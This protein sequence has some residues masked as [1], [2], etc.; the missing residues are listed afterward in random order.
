MEAGVNSRVDMSCAG[1]DVL[2]ALLQ[3]VGFLD[4]Y[5]SVLLGMSLSRAKRGN[6]FTEVL[7]EG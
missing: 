1:E 6:C 7:I 5:I 3:S 4:E 2:A